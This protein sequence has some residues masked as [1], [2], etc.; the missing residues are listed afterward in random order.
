MTF[1]RYILLSLFGLLSFSNP[2]ASL[3]DSLA[4][5][6]D[7]IYESK[8]KDLFLYF[9]QNPE[10]STMEHETSARLAAELNALG[11]TVHT[12][13]GGTGIVALLENGDGPLVMFRADMDGLPVEEKS[14]LSYSSRAKQVDPNG[15]EVFV[16]HA[17]G[18]DVHITSLVGTAQLMVQKRDQWQGTLMLI[19]QPAEERVMGAAAMRADNLW[20]RFGQPDY[21]MAFH[22]TSAIPTGILG[23]STDSPYSG[24]DTVDIYIT[25]VGAHGASPHRGV[26]PIVLGSQIVMGLQTVVSRTLPPRR[27][28]VITVGAFHS[29]TK[30]NIISDAAHLQLTVRSESTEDRALLLDGIRRVAE[31]M[32]RVAGLP[33]DLLPEVVISN[34]SVPPT[35]NDKSLT[36]RVMA[37]WTDHFGEGVLFSGERLGMGAE[38]FPIFTVDPYIPS[39]YFAVGG[40]PPEDFARERAGGAPVPSHHSPLFKVE[41]DASVTMGVEASVTA[42]LELL[43]S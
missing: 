1:F 2:Q 30:H 5:E 15:N 43:D 16:M 19:G 33:D 18:H 4:Q 11:Y 41:P 31:N 42:L 29:G 12:N 17:C 20:Q 10:L 36:E 7:A 9:H 6:I 39:L 3:A 28:G 21:A 37:L 35:L 26:D 24:A 40:T 27:P 32:G 34:E 8:L 23:A 14:G 13:V 22:V 25:G 38:D